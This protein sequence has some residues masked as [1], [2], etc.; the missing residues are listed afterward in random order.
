MFWDWVFDAHPLPIFLS[1]RS[2]PL[3]QIS[4]SHWTW[5]I[6]QEDARDPPLF[7]M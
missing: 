1:G 6:Q 4:D 3:H 5:S 7:E 2:P